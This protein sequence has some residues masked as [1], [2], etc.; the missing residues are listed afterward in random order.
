MKKIINKQ[1]ATL[2]E[3]IVGAAVFSIC[4]LILVTGF[5]AAGSMI[6]KGLDL[7]HQSEKAAAAIEGASSYSDILIKKTD[8]DVTFTIDGSTVTVNGGYT[9]AE[10]S[11]GNEIFTEFEPHSK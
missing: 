7:S 4:A 8:G 2:V 11:S 5:T 6:K 10:D 9:A 1:G 3:A